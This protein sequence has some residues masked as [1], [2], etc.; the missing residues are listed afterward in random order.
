MLYDLNPVP[1]KALTVT[2][3]NGPG[4]K[5]IL[6]KKVDGYGEPLGGAE[7]SLYDTY[8]HAEAGGS[9]GLVQVTADQSKTDKATSAAAFTTTDGVAYNVSFKAGNGIYYMKEVNTVT[10]YETNTHVYRVA[11]GKAGTTVTKDSTSVE[12]PSDK[13]YLIQCMKNAD[14][15][16]STPDVTEYGIV[17]ISKSQ[18]KVILKKIDNQTYAPLA[19]AKFQ[20]LRY[21]R[22]L[23]ESTDIVGNT[24]T[25]FTSGENGVYFIDNLPYGTYYIHET[26]VPDGYQKLDDETNW[27]ILTV[28]ESGVTVSGR[29]SEAP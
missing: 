21:D 7:F 15:V 11:V 16:E 14:E 10:G 26:T 13:E 24:T 20:I 6:F 23:V 17:N 12:L 22:T 5:E 8:A 28:N 9:T 18:S 29:L 2:F 1:T 27:Y 19:G 4:G 3:T 25:T